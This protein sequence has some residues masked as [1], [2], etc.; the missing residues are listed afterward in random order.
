MG[1]RGADPPWVKNPCITSQSSHNIL[2]STFVD[3]T[4]HW[5]CSIRYLPLKKKSVCKW[6]S[7]VQTHLIQA[8][9][10]Y[11]KIQLTF[12]YRPFSNL[13][14]MTSLFQ[15]F[16]ESIFHV[17]FLQRKL[18]H[19]EKLFFCHVSLSTTSSMV[20]SGS[21]LVANFEGEKHSGFHH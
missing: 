2:G 8:S 4:N 20:F 12:I 17:N 11:K 18:C 16:F 19:L 1:H 3:S 6:I 10:T 7:A 13:A 5:W 15:E 14:K 21:Y 9:T